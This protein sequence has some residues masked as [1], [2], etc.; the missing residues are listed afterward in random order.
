MRR[1]ILC[2]VLLLALP[3]LACSFS[4]DLGGDTEEPTAALPPQEIATAAPEQ[5]LPTPAAP[6]AAEARLHSVFFASRIT[7]DEEPIDVAA[8][9]S[10]GIA[11]VYAFASY[12]GM[13]DGTDCESV[14]YLDGEEVARTPF[15][16][17]AGPTGGPLMIA[18]IENEGGLP[19]GGYEWELYVDDQLKA[20]AGF[21]V[22]G[23]APVLYEDDFSDPGSGWADAELEG[24]RVGYLDGLYYVSSLTEG[25]LIWVSAGVS[26]SDVV[27]NVEATQAYAGPEND[28][29]YGVMCRV[30]SN[31]DGYLL[32]ISGDGYYSIHKRLGDEY[33]ALVDWSTSEAIRQGNSRNDIQAVC[34][35][36]QLALVVNGQLLAEANDSI[37][38]EGDVGLVVSSYE[39][40]AT[41]V[42]FDN[43]VVTRPGASP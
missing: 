36:S 32:R 33:V 10:L 30:Q 22:R 9:F 15:V 2:V 28:N 26:L 11:S 18:Y 6:P 21:P 19:A 39:D 23:L 7:P 27:I 4:F 35:G 16:W 34:D 8:E 25:T 17:A 12:E 5:P 14:W 24:G 3:V 43:L 37:F 38:A 40:A 1:W 41:E 13:S 29:S 42:S 31:D 20:T